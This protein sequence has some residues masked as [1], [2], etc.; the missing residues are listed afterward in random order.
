[1]TILPND[2][3]LLS[4]LRESDQNALQEIYLRYWKALFISA[5]NILKDKNACEDILQD[6]FLHLWHNRSS[7]LIHSS[8]QAYL[9]TAVRFQVLKTLRNSARRDIL[10]HQFEASPTPVSPAE[11]LEEKEILEN[12]RTVVESLPPKCRRIYQLSREQFL[13][14]KEIAAKL[15]ISE[16][17][18]EN[19]LSIALK[20]IR[21]A[22]G[23]LSALFF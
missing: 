18:V 8:L 2:E 3:P 15:K 16:K 19:Q 13:S 12:I 21:K 11:N 14:H 23:Q 7:L 4:R 1:M 20:K 9:Y 10:L 22:L 17:T 5:Y 6:V